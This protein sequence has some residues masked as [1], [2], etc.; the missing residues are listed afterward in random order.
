MYCKFLPIIT[1][2]ALL[3]LSGNVRAQSASTSGASE[4]TIT[5]LRVQVVITRFEGEKKLSSLPYT[6]VVSTSKLGNDGSARIRLGVDA[7]ITIASTPDGSPNSA[8][9]QYRSIGTNIDSGN[10]TV[11]PD[12]RY[13]FVISVQNTAAVPDSA[14]DAKGSRPLFRRFDATVYPV[15]R[16][17][18][19]MQTVA[20]AD[21]VTGEVVKIDVTI[22]VLR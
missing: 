8:T 20:S 11:L 19:T 9:V 5:S 18:Q 10:V 13:Q 2:A 6:F 14:S 16:D 12:G 7:P 4:A 21:P 22:N 17:G 3:A 1:S 15:L